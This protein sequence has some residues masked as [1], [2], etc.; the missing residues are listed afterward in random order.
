M[1]VVGGCAVAVGEGEL[2]LWRGRH[3]VELGLVGLVLLLGIWLGLDDWRCGR[4]VESLLSLP[5]EEG[6]P[7]C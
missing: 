7:P 3:A 5:L 6:L 1:E 4:A 2:W